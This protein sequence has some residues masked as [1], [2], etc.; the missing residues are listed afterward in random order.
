MTRDE[1][2]QVFERLRGRFAA[3]HP[4]MAKVRLRLARKHFL[5]RPAARDLAWYEPSERTVY[6]MER[7]LAGHAG[8]VSGLLAHELGHAADSDTS[9]PYAELRADALAKAAI[10]RPIRY[11]AGDV[12]N[13]E[14]GVTPRPPYLHENKPMKRNPRTPF[15]NSPPPASS[16]WSGFARAADVGELDL[17]AIADATGYGGWYSLDRSISPSTIANERN[18]PSGSVRFTKF[19]KAIRAHSLKLSKASADRIARALL[20]ER[21]YKR[22]PTTAYHRARGDAQLVLAED[23]YKKAKA[24]SR[25]GDA[26]GAHD[27]LIHAHRMAALAE[28]DLTD[29]AST[30]AAK[31]KSL[32]WWKA[33]SQL[34]QSPKRNP[35]VL[36][37]AGLAG[38]GYLLL[39]AAGK[40]PSVSSVQKRRFGQTPPTPQ[41]NMAGETRRFLV[42]GYDGESGWFESVPR[43]S[44]RSAVDT[45]TK[46][47]E[48]AG[49]PK[50]AVQEWKGNR[51]MPAVVIERP[52]SGW[53][54]RN[55]SVIATI[56]AGYRIKNN[57]TGEVW[58]V[59][60]AGPKIRG[61]Q[62]YV[63]KDVHGDKHSLRR[64]DLL[65]GQ[66]DGILT[67]LDIANRNP[68]KGYKMPEAQARHT[69]EGLL[70]RMK[71]DGADTFAKKVKWVKKHM[72]NIDR[73]RTFVGWVTKG[74]RGRVVYQRNPDASYAE[75]VKAAEDARAKLFRSLKGK[76]KEDLIRILGGYYRIHGLTTKSSITDLKYA[77]TSAAHPDPRPPRSRNPKASVKQQI[78][79]L[80][81]RIKAMEEAGYAPHSLIEKRDLLVAKVRRRKP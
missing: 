64:E 31:A 27:S 24:M 77:I 49:E 21:P 18:T 5:K 73:P 71:A 80:D 62:R 76:T 13:L 74:E 63:V 52:A 2:H 46:E 41:R 79:A 11:D 68:A 32:T 20:A 36:A 35:S 8:R 53:T 56:R 12:Q 4:A 59:M 10:G 48:Y 9:R 28:S 75:R 17:D 43:S 15:S 72:P 69:A 14:V 61:T 26:K 40:K 30:K 7:A 42:W 78:L 38:A 66:K 58:T 29:G 50:F 34:A 33:Y 37:L 39:K 65:Q 55:P 22:N 1:A 81:R 23:A 3:K 45:G 67:I 16:N 70:A 60:G 51:W 44:Y 54:K 25:R 19:A 57:E 47:A 6:L